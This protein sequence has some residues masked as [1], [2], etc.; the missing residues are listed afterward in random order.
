MLEKE[1]FAAIL[2]IGLAANS[3]HPRIE[4]K[5]RDILDFRIPDNSGR[6]ISNTKITGNG[7]LI[8]NNKPS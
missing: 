7:G 2:H 8:F 1:E 5:A 3:V 6:Q 4:I